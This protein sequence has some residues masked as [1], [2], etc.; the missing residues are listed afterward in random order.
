MTDFYYPVLGDEV[1]LPIFV[2]GAGASE[3]TTRISAGKKV[4][5][6]FEVSDWDKKTERITF[7]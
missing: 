3:L 6:N 7:N 1:S 2:L 4:S 5:F